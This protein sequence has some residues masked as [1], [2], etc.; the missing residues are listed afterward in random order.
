MTGPTCYF[1]CWL[2][3]GGLESRA[4]RIFACF[5]Y[6]SHSPSHL[7]FM[8]CCCHCHAASFFTCFHSLSFF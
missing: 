2:A 6:Q 4:W 5:S 3:R 7:F 8:F 1:L